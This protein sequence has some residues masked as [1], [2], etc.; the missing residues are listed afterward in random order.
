MDLLYRIISPPLAI[1]VVRLHPLRVFR[2]GLYA[3]AFT[4][5]KGI[6]N[7][8]FKK[9]ISPPKKSLKSIL[10]HSAGR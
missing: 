7:I 3:F 5:S 6:K 4:H 2:Y 8:P 1:A 10:R 9:N